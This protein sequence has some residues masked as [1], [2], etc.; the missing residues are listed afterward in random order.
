MFEEVTREE[1]QGFLKDDSP[2]TREAR[3]ELSYW[4]SCVRTLGVRTV[5]GSVRLLHTIALRE[6]SLASRML[7]SGIECSAPDLLRYSAQIAD[8][9][10]PGL[11]YGLIHT[12]VSY[13][14][15]Q[16]PNSVGLGDLLGAT[17]FVSTFDQPRWS[18]AASVV[19]RLAK[20]T[21][22]SEEKLV[23]I[24]KGTIPAP[25]ARHQLL[26]V[27]LLVTLGENLRPV[28]S[29]VLDSG[30]HPFA[31]TEQH[32]LVRVGLTL[33]AFGVFTSDELDS[34][35][36]MLSNEQASEADFQRFLTKHPKFLYLLGDYE[37]YRR[38]VELEPGQAISRPT[39]A[40]D[41][42]F[43]HEDL[44]AQAMG[45]VDFMLKRS[46]SERWDPVELK[47]PTTR[48]VVG[49]GRRMTFSQEIHYAIAQLREYVKR[50]RD[51]HV[52]QRLMERYGLRVSSPKPYLLVGRDYNEPMLV[53]R[54]DWLNHD[55]ASDIGIYTYDRLL[56]MAERRRIVLGRL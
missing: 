23:G 56:R 30:E 3:E 11:S 46:W 2:L 27:S 4:L 18:S 1:V 14:R 40:T 43:D 41:I 48:I 32:R 13:L 54:V 22:F 51:R 42:A 19:R 33:P 28:V 20:H 38:E 29:A 9:V 36:E 6:D 24:L 49:A 5:E 21:S 17:L 52:R 34:F 53:D 7:T 8:D 26:S 55:I 45:R 10:G 39:I 35:A 50:L 12:D 31:E 47:L 44:A 37:D 15:T 16:A 25:K